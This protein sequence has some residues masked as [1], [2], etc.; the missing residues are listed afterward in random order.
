MR[1]GDDDYTVAYQGAPGAF[2]EEAAVRLCGTAAILRPCRT[3]EDVFA[4]LD[5]GDAAAAVIPVENSIAG[6]VPGSR[7]LVAAHGAHV[8]KRLAL[9]VV[10]ALIAAPGVALED[11]R[12]VR[13]HPMALAQCRGFLDAHAHLTAVATFDTA[14]AVADLMREGTRSAAAIASSRAADRW[15]AVVLQQGVQDRADNS[16]EFWLVSVRD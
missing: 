6:D 10:H 13:S 8:K 1:D 3:L 12:E 5:A 15:G 2:S 9:S 7:S 16:T 11:I 14:G 4:A